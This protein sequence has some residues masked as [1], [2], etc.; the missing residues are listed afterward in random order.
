MPVQLLLAAP[1]AALAKL[2]PA[3][4][5][6]LYGRVPDRSQIP[7]TF[8]KLF[9]VLKPRRLAHFVT[10]SGDEGLVLQQLLEAGFQCYGSIL[11]RTPQL[12]SRSRWLECSHLRVLLVGKGAVPPPPTRLADEWDLRTKGPSGR[13]AE[14]LVQRALSEPYL[15][16]FFPRQGQMLD[17]WASP[18]SVLACYRAQRHALL[19]QED[20]RIFA[21]LEQA[22]AQQSRQ[23]RLAL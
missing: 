16:Q 13:L 10:D 1:A 18:G 12:S 6:Y 23:L 22:L 19:I 2:R 15:Q 5:D 3:S 9:S 7:T 14:R 8:Q 17:P 4:R 21:L 11:A 20:P